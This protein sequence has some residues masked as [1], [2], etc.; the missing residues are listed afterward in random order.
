[1]PGLAWRVD[2]DAVWV[3]PVERI[4]VRG[5]GRGIALRRAQAGTDFWG[6]VE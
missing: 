6:R 3:W 4:V 2:S 5:E 1:L